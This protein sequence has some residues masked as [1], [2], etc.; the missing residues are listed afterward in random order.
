MS[1]INHIS[2]TRFL[3]EC[4]KQTKF[5]KAYDK[6]CNEI[7]KKTHNNFNSYQLY[8][9]YKDKSLSVKCDCGLIIECDLDNDSYPFLNLMSHHH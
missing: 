9:Y 8:S 1:S 2:T 3:M 7:I 6:C 4:Y 5:Y